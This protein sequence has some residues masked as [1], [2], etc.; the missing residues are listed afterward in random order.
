M[1][2][3]EALCTVQEVVPKRVHWNMTSRHNNATQHHTASGRTQQPVSFITVT[4]VITCTHRLH[5]QG[6]EPQLCLQS[7]LLPRDL[8]VEAEPPAPGGRR[9]K[10]CVWG[11]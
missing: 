3:N 6:L 8:G 10:V 2:K 11:G 1:P 5:E 4:V 7:N 9:G